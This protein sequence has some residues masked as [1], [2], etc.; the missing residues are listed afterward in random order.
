ME[1]SC[2]L[3][4]S[5]LIF[6]EDQIIN[7]GMAGE[8]AVLLLMEEIHLVYSTYSLFSYLELGQGV[9]SVVVKDI[10]ILA[11]SQTCNG[12]SYHDPR[13]DMSILSKG[14]SLFLIV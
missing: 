4:F 9:I 3:S 10:E 12:R 8:P 11:L 6:P 7:G 5:S 13:A 2:W 14:L 1:S